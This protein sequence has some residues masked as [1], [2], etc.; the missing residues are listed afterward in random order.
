MEF[1]DYYEVMGVARDASPEDVKRAYRR[2]SRK[3]HPDVSSEANAEERF[4]E[5]GEAYEVLKDPEKRAAYDELGADWQRGQDFRPP[6]EWEYSGGGASAA[7]DF[8][9]FF[10]GLF[11]GRG[12]D[13]RSRADS[14]G[15]DVAARI[16]LSLEEAFR[17]GEQTVTLQRVERGPDGQLRRAQQTLKV[18]IPAG[19]TA[20]Q[21]I[22]LR[23][24]GEPGLQGTRGD[25][26]LE[27]QL[28]P[29]KWFQVQGKD[30]IVELPVAP[31]EAALGASVRVPTLDGAVN[32]KIPAGSDTGRRLRLKGKGLPGNPPGDQ[33]VVLK[34]SVPPVESERVK[35]LYESLA[36]AVSESPR[37]DMEAQT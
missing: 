32:M 1:K 14:F 21:Q 22:R 4:K 29:H 24:Q 9:D 28:R 17:G 16:E 20:G 3:Y 13:P 7:R 30:V 34:V 19:V 11:G 31:W 8:S 18:N 33:W 6:P 15:F 37:R 35:S 27:V 2:L 26:F 12:P 23:G 25:L 36:E 5:I 10:E